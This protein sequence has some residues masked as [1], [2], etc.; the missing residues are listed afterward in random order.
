[1]KRLIAI[2][3][4]GFARLAFWRKPAAPASDQAEPAAIASRETAEGAEPA[5]V[6]HADGVAD[7]V[8]D[9]STAEAR[10]DEAASA[11]GEMGTAEAAAPATGIRRVLAVLSNKWVLISSIGGVLLAI[12]GV[13]LFMLMQSSRDKTHLQAELLKTQK[14]LEQSVIAKKPEANSII[15]AL[16]PISAPTPAPVPVPEQASEPAVE[17]AAPVA[18]KAD[19]PVT[20]PQPAVASGECLITDQASVTQNLKNCIESFNRA[21]ERSRSTR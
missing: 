2:C 17:K 1:M 11:S 13:A 4:Q 16:A 5:E 8:A 15:P 3:A 21:T 7:G 12:T 9:E 18:E 20:K 6:E 10:H 14:Q 19:P